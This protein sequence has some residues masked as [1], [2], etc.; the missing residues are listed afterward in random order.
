[1]GDTKT[2]VERL[3][4]TAG[5]WQQAETITIFHP[6]S[7]AKMLRET[8]DALASHEAR[9]AELEEALRTARAY[10][11]EAVHSRDPIIAED[12]VA[13]IKRINGAL[14]KTKGTK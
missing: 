7:S 8:A 13:D 3:L 12:T 2:L 10:V 5:L 11:S 1:M 6:P 4:A 14:A 9:I